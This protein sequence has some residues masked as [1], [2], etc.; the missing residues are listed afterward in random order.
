M[1]R[2]S[3]EIKPRRWPW[4]TTALVL[5]QIYVFTVERKAMAWGIINALIDDYSFRWTTFLE[6]PLSMFPQIFTHLFLH[7]NTSHLVG[8][9]VFFL[10][11]APAVENAMGAVY[12]LFAYFVWGVAAALTQG[13]FDPFSLGLIG[14]SGA[15]SGAAGAFFVLFPLRMPADFLG[16]VVGKTIARIPAFFLIG[17]W[18]LGQL[19]DGFRMLMPDPLADK[20]VRVAYWAH[21]GGFTAGAIS[22][23]PLLVGNRRKNGAF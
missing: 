8:N 10:L 13:F 4:A 5:A 3:A 21:L 12:F 16:R 20:V 19:H 14:A 18:M 9:L 22:V 1:A 23:F 17:I 15:I 7:A 6:A 2:A 11:F